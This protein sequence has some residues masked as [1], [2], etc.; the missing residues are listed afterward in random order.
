ML[1][2]SPNRGSLHL[3]GHLAVWGGLNHC[4]ALFSQCVHCQGTVIHSELHLA[5]SANQSLIRHESSE[6]WRRNL[7]SWTIQTTQTAWRG[8]TSHNR[9]R[10]RFRRRERIKAGE[11]RSALWACLL[12]DCLRP[13]SQPFIAPSFPRIA[14]RRGWRAV[15]GLAQAPERA[16]V[17]VQ[18]QQYH[19]SA[20]CSP[21]VLLSHISLYSHAYLSWTANTVFNFSFLVT[22]FFAFFAFIGGILYCI[23]YCIFICS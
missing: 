23:L 1:A 17:S 13:A 9:C 6:A 7:H 8:Q 2:P 3:E 21:N 14:S 19:L 15:P 5:R 4:S 16:T 11:L 22:L 12:L 18:C 10:G 20:G